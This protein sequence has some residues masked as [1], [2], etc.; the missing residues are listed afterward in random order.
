M[1]DTSTKQSQPVSSCE[2]SAN[3]WKEVAKQIINEPDSEKLGS[4]VQELCDILDKTHK[5]PVSVRLPN[6]STKPNRTM[7]R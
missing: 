4:L 7:S 2:P 3:T 1:Q 5:P 6:V